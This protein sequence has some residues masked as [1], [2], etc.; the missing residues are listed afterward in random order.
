ML[1]LRRTHAYVAYKLQKY[2]ESLRVTE[3]ILN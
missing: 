1:E 3:I 2:I